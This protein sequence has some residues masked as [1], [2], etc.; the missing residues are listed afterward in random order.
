M[1]RATTP[2]HEL[3]FAEGT[4]TGAVKVLVSYKQDQQ[5]RDVI[6]NNADNDDIEVDTTR[7][8]VNVYWTQA[9]ANAFVPNRQMSV[10]ARIKYATTEVVATNRVPVDVETVFNDSV[11]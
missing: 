3:C 10:Q 1:I 5:S 8:V 6:W 9:Q 7:D 4:L 2:T 11:I